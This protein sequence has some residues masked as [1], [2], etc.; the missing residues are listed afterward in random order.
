MHIGDN[1]AF[2]IGCSFGGWRSEFLFNL[3]APQKTTFVDRSPE[4][5]TKYNRGALKD[6]Y[7][8]KIGYKL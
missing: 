8:N 4:I 3:A 1:N 5:L 2:D 7:K 6:V